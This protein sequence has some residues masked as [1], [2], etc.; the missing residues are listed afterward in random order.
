MSTMREQELKKVNGGMMGGGTLGGSRFNEG[1][2]VMS[3]ANP[4]FGVGTVT[5]KK[6]SRGW[7]YYVENNGKKLYAPESDLQLALLQ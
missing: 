2:R 3:Q 4:D 1:D 7:H 5:G 6:Y